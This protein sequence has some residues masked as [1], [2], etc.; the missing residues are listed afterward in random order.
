VYVNGRRRTPVPATGMI[1]F[2]GCAS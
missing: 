1:A 2:I